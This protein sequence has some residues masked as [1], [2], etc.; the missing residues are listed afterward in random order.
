MPPST[1]IMGYRRVATAAMTALMA[2]TWYV[3]TPRDLFLW[4]PMCMTIAYCWLM[5]EGVSVGKA[6][7]EAHSMAARR[8]FTQSHTIVF[9]LA[10]IFSTVGV[11]AIYQNKELHNKPHGT[12]WHGVTGYIAMLCMLVQ[13]LMGYTL[14]FSL[15]KPPMRALVRKT[16]AAVAIGASIIGCSAMCLGLVSSFAAMKLEQPYR[17][18]IGI[19]LWLFHVGALAGF[20]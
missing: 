10:L 11:G 7:G 3:G 4:H 15:G 12:S 20:C 17:L 19:F 16:H 5:I 18:S 8:R 13:S 2:Y 6:V 9:T 14:Y 1:A